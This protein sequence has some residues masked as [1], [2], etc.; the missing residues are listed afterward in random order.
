MEIN[1]LTVLATIINFVIL[2]FI[3]RHFLI[4]PVTSTISARED[5]IKGRIARAENDEK[6]A[7]LLRIENEEKIKNA[8]EEGKTIIEDLKVKAE[9]VSETII[10]KAKEEAEFLLERARADAERER[11]KASEDI[12]TQT[13]DLAL[14][15][16]SK[17]LGS[18]IDENEH[19]RLIKDFI[20][21]VG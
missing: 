10:S 15:L 11:E 6:K 17:A 9:R 5:E 1:P 12:K 16:S 7:E 18:T 3:L 8:K 19:R 20:A 2:Y 21:K 13:I 14:I 4:E